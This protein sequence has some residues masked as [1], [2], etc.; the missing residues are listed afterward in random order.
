MP[1]KNGVVEFDINKLTAAQCYELDNYVND[2]IQ[3][4][5]QMN[6]ASLSVGNIPG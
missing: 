6:P 5:Q 3:K 1:S 4:K 2:C